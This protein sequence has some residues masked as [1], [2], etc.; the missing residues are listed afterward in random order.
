M[1]EKNKPILE[2]RNPVNSYSDTIVM[3]IGVLVG[4]AMDRKAKESGKLLDVELKY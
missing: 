3:G 2:S 1:L 4:A